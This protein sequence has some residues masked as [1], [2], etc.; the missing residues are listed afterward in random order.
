MKLAQA[1]AGSGTR[2]NPKSATAAASKVKL[3]TEDV[4]DTPSPDSSEPDLKNR[5]MNKPKVGIISF[6][7][8][9]YV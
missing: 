1:F 7:F 6:L 4:W 8:E 3:K 2:S 5:K 9:S